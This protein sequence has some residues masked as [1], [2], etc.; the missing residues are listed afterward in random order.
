MSSTYHTL[1]DL[2]LAVMLLHFQEVVGEVQDV[3]APLLAQQGDDHTAGPVESV[4]KAL[5]EKTGMVNN[6]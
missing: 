4:T 5:P 3:K 1:D 6:E 2:I